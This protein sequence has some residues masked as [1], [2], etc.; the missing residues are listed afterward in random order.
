LLRTVTVPLAAEVFTPCELDDAGRWIGCQQLVASGGSA[1]VAD[2]SASPVV[3]REFADAMVASGAPLLLTET[4]LRP[5]DQ[6]QRIAIGQGKDDAWYDTAGS[7]YA[8]VAER[9]GGPES[10][11]EL[12]DGKAG[13]R[14][15]RV[16]RDAFRGYPAGFAIAPDTSRVVVMVRPFEEGRPHSLISLSGA[17]GSEQWR[18]EIADT[19]MS[20][21]TP[22]W[23]GPDGKEVVL[24]F[25]RAG[26]Y[27]RNELDG[28][29][30][31]AFA[32]GDGS[33]QRRVSLPGAGQAYRGQF[34]EEMRAGYDGKVVWFYAFKPVREPSEFNVFGGVGLEPGRELPASCSYEVYDARQ[35]DP[36]PLRTAAD[37]KGEIG[38]ALRECRVLA[39]RPLAGKQV[40]AV[41]VA[42][43]R[44][45]V[46]IFDG[47]P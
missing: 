6:D 11:I 42:V 39:M 47:P 38:N 26:D 9:R 28:A 3:P 29:Q 41:I 44:L 32:S 16:G 36:R 15:W 4:D 1:L 22:I 30:L 34:G 46:D 35:P 27:T 37:V 45:I 25:R 23:F 12:Y 24:L 14:R 18:H 2:L 20:T 19:G 40:A 33:E 31:V 21:R 17:D 13:V 8:R 5:F 7:T 10:A 43:D